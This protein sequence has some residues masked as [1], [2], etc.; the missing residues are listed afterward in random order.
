MLYFLLVTEAMWTYGPWLRGYTLGNQG[1]ERELG[2]PHVNKDLLGFD[3]QLD[4]S[5]GQRL[6]FSLVGKKSGDKIQGIFLDAWGKSGNWTATPS[7]PAAPNCPEPS[8]A[9]E[10]NII[11]VPEVTQHGHVRYPSLAREAQIQGQVRMRVSTDTYC[12]A[13]I[14]TDSGDPILA[15][16]AEANVRTWFFA[17]HKPGT[18]D[19]TF[20]YRFLK[21]EVSFLE[22]PGVV[23]ILAMPVSLGG[24]ESGLGNY[25]GYSP[26][27]WEAQLMSRHGQMQTTFNFEYGCCEK[28]RATDSSGD[29]EKIIQ[30]FRSDHDVGFSTIVRL[31]NGRRTRVSLIGRL[32]DDRIQGVFLDEFGTPVTWSARII[33]HGYV[34]T[35]EL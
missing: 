15:Q 31:A 4:D 16:A 35:S 14:S 6:W 19:L 13:K 18:F 5:F 26:E 34:N 17:S 12:V 7:K 25:G 10:K 2:N 22:K 21:P 24:P 20:N 33:S 28:G 1:Q 8:A 23:E 27:I 3:A 29:T 30:G 32:R 11:P 9:A